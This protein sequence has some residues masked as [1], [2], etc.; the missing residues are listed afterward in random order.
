MKNAKRVLSILLS[1]M[2]A[3]G[4]VAVGG[5]SASAEYPLPES[6]DIIYDSDY[7]DGPIVITENKTI[8]LKGVT[9]EGTDTDP[10][11]I[12]IE[13]GVTLNIILSGEN[14]LTAKSDKLSAGIFVKREV[15]DDDPYNPIDAVLNI[16]LSSMTAR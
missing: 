9:I 15:D 3:L 5:V 16:Y 11:P 10:S 12:T 14:T 7:Q 8:E 1:L 6:V 13:P 4:A 2:L